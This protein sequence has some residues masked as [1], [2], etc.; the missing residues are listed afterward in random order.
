MSEFTINRIIIGIG[1]NTDTADTAVRSAMEWCSETFSNTLAS[2]VYTTAPVGMKAIAAGRD[3]CNGVIAAETLLSKEDVIDSLKNY[4]INHGRDISSRSSG[5]VPIDLDL[6]VY[7]DMI[8]RPM[9]FE[10]DYFR[11]GFEEIKI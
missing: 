9:D 2:S 1:S 7:N 8:L 5:I 3:Y 11:R 4:E 6:V 10:R